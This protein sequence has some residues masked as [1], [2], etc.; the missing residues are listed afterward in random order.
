MFSC[1]A[2]RWGGEAGKPA[3]EPGRKRAQSEYHTSAGGQ[4]PDLRQSGR[5]MVTKS[6]YQSLE[7]ALASS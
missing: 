3:A 2:R 4:D 5:D 6:E 1:Q 7:K